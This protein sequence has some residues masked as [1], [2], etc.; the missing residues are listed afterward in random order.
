MGRRKKTH[1][2]LAYALIPRSMYGALGRGHID[3]TAFAVWATIRLYVRDEERGEFSPPPVDLTNRELAEATGLTVRQTVNVLNHLEDRGLL[4]RLT[5]AE[6]ET[7]SLPGNRWL[8]LLQ[9]IS[10]K[11]ISLKSE[12]EASPSTLDN[13][14]H[15]LSS[16][17]D[18]AF[19]SS[20]LEGGMGGTENVAADFNEMGCN[21]KNFNETQFRE[22]ARDLQVCGVYRK[23]AYQIATRMLQEE[24]SRTVDW[25]KDTFYRVFNEERQAAVTDDVAMRRTVTRLKNG[26]WGSLDAVVAEAER[27]KQDQQPTPTPSQLDRLLTPPQLSPAQKVWGKVLQEVELQ[28]TRSTFD[29]WLRSTQALEIEG[30]TL[31][32]QAQNHYAVEWLTSRLHKPILRSLRDIVQDWPSDNGGGLVAQVCDVNFVVSGE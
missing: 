21:E 30:A 31:V 6:R 25:A 12:E 32:V 27:R 7:K 8:Q 15:G 17:G 22:I 13:S 29:T 19:S 10:M 26:D 9:P 1:T 28:L 4:H 2:P 11:S 24:A 23:P 5:D 14:I 20:K 18:S 3:P 16:A